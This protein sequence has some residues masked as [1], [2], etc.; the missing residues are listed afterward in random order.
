MIIYEVNLSVDPAIQ[1]EFE[2]WLT[3]H[4]DQMLAIPGFL[5]AECMRVLD[6]DSER[7]ELCVQYR[8]SDREALQRYLADQAASMRGDGLA[9][10]GDRFST[11][12]RVLEL[13]SG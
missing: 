10:F 13:Q 8:L 3:D 9:R 2:P 12:R 11:S 4:V 1:R 7:V 5:D 6:E